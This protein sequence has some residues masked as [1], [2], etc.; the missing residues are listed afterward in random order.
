MAKGEKTRNNGVKCT[1]AQKEARLEQ[2]VDWLYRNPD[3]RWSEFVAHF[4][5]EF[6]I[7][8]NTANIYW[9][10]AQEKLGSD[11]AEELSAD[12][13]RAVVRLII[14]LKAA[15]KAGDT[16]LQLEISKE[17]NKIQGLHSTK[18]DVTSDGEKV[19]PIDLKSLISFNA[20]KE[21]DGSEG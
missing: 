2:C 11:V 16:K 20:P 15:Q 21:D 19:E 9:K 18:V 1:P 17:I 5:A 13:K 3:G 6:D 4:K 10:E 12:R 7:L 14:Q 8:K